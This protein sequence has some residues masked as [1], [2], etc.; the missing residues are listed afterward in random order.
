VLLIATINPV[1]ACVSE[2]IASL[3]FASRLSSMH[4]GSSGTSPRRARP[5]KGKGSKKVEVG[6]D[7]SAAQK[8]KNNRAPPKR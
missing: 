5:R 7:S 3:Q 8:N 2:S 4:A 1:E 6:N